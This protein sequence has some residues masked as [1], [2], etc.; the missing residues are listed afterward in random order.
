MLTWGGLENAEERMSVED[1]TLSLQPEGNPDAPC[2]Q[3][4]NLPP[5]Q[6]VLL[7]H[8]QDKNPPHLCQGTV[9]GL[10]RKVGASMVVTGT[11]VQP[12]SSG[13][14]SQLSTR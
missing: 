9:M 7:S 5:L 12:E 10:M 4:F 6:P 2:R 11:D 14:K 1:Y 3:L 8:S 13:I